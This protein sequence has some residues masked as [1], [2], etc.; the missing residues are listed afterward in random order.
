MGH[1][2]RNCGLTHR[3]PARSRH[4][5]G[6][7]QLCHRQRRATPGPLLGHPRRRRQ[8]W[9]RD[10]VPLPPARHRYRIRRADALASGQ[11][12]GGHAVVSGVHHGR[13]G[14]YQRL[15]CL[16]RSSRRGRPSPSICTT[17]T[18]CGIVWCY[19]GPLE[20]ADAGL[21]AHPQPFGAPALDFV[22]PM[23]H[24]ALQSMFDPLYPPGLP[25]VLERRLRQRVARC[26]HRPPYRVRRPACPAMHSTMHLYPIDG[27]AGRVGAG[28]YGLGLSRRHMGH[29]HGGRRSRPGQRRQDHVLDARAIGTRCIPIPPA[30]PTST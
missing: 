1:L 19:T 21:C 10:L 12:E 14:R 18:M 8:L 25:V 5:A 22:G 24:P 6:R 11:N 27:A 3:Q 15:L 29:G 2:S 16:S 9:R 28:R 13:P 7:R 30:A 23:P 17:R 26:R 4:G 20:Q